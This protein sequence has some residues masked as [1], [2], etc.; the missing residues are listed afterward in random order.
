[1]NK[2]PLFLKMH[3][4]TGYDVKL[5]E[6]KSEAQRVSRPSGYLQTVLYSGYVRNY[7]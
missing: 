6:N 4:P 2:R 3:S 7:F 1:M 5:F